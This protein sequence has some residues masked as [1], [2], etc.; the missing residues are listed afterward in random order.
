MIY[1]HILLNFPPFIE[2]SSS[3]TR[4]QVWEFLAWHILVITGIISGFDACKG[5]ISVWFIKEI[6][7]IGEANFECIRKQ[8]IIY[9]PLLTVLLRHYFFSS[10][11]FCRGRIQRSLGHPTMFGSTRLHQLGM[12][13][14]LMARQPAYVSVVLSIM[15]QKPERRTLQRRVSAAIFSVTQSQETR[16][17]SRVWHGSFHIAIC[18][19]LLSYIQNMGPTTSVYS[20]KLTLRMRWLGL[21]S[22]L[23]PTIWVEIILIYS[24]R[25]NLTRMFVANQYSWHEYGN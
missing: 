2:W 10:I 13:I 6:L 12:G 9:Y 21:V 3:K 5:A 11:H 24:I 14:H 25:S 7:F 19:W 18:R 1:D 8:L 17:R 20:I 15:I 22:S 4:W 23:V 16:F